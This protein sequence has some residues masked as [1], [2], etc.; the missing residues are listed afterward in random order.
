[1][2]RGQKTCSK[3]GEAT[4]PRSFVCPKCGQ[5][6]SFKPKFLRPE[7]G[8][9]IPDWRKLRRGDE[10]KVIAGSGPIW[11]TEDEDINMGYNGKFIV[12]GMDVDGLHAYPT[13]K[14]AESG[15]CYI[16]MA[17]PKQ[18]KHGTQLKPHKII[19]LKSENSENS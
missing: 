15:H 7:K 10:I 2:P 13:G 3:C 12:H 4:G 18:G 17:E 11:E 19:L 16:Y 5:P 14:T 8:Q 6:F 1:M 9:D